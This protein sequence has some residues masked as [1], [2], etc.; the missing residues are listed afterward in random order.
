MGREQTS[1]DTDGGFEDLGSRVHVERDGLDDV[2]DRCLEPLNIAHYHECVED[3]D[4]C[5]RV[6]ACNIVGRPVVTVGPIKMNQNLQQVVFT[7][8]FVRSG[9]RPTQAIGSSS[10]YGKANGWCKCDASL[11]V[12]GRTDHGPCSYQNRDTTNPVPSR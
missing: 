1:E 10:S 11:M 8:R 7:D 2:L 12:G 5:H 9:P 6:I 4:K 3:V